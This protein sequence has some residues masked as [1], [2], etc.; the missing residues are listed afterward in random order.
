MKYQLTITDGK[1]RTLNL[2]G[3]DVAELID[4][5]KD[6]QD[7]DSWKASMQR[8]GW[9]HQKISAEK[10]SGFYYDE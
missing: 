2:C 9:S 5:I 3:N 6:W 8:L 1:D 4:K 10:R 7:W